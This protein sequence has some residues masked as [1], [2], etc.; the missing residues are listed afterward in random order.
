MPEARSTDRPLRGSTVRDVAARYRVSPAKVRGWISRGELSAIN[1]ADVACGRPRWLV[2]PD[3]LLAFERRRAA[4]PETK[5][6]RRKRQ[7]VPIDYYP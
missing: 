4:A 3:A 6:A 1:T 5:P 2:L 7:S